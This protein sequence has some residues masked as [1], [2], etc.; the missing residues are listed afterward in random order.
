MGF[1]T[2]TP[3]VQAGVTRVLDTPFRIS[4]DGPC[5]VIYTLELNCTAPLLS[6]EFVQVELYVS[7]DNPPISLFDTARLESSQLAG[8][9]LVSINTKT[10]QIVSAWVATNN[11]IELKKTGTGD[12]TLVAQ[13][14]VCFGT[15]TG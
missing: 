2:D 8:L 14:E 15:V 13:L 6:S 3:N 4:T 9:G 11:F 7:P 5:L 1:L 10:R 12:A